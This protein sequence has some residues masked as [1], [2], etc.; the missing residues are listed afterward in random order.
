MKTLYIDGHSL[1]LDDVREVAFGQVQVRIKEEA[2]QKIFKAREL[3][4]HKVASGEIVYGLTT[5][6]GEFKN[7]AINKDQTKELQDNLIASHSIGVGEP[8]SEPI[9]RVAT[10]IR[11]NSLSSGNSGVRL[12]TVEALLDIPASS[13]GANFTTNALS[14]ALRWKRKIRD[15]I[16]PE[17][18]EPTYCASSVFSISLMSIR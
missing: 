5:G 7:V 18:Y 15:P 3:V 4:E 16:C 12:E 9:V 6:F 10:L 8:F 2:K 1:T 14:S 17:T 11:A 13:E